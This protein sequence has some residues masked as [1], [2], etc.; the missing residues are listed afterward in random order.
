MCV[1]PASHHIVTLTE[2]R[3]IDIRR[4]RAVIL[5]EDI[6]MNKISCRILS[7]SR[8]DNAS[9][10][11]SLYKHEFVYAATT[12]SRTISLLEPIVSSTGYNGKIGMV[13]DTPMFK[14]CAVSFGVIVREAETLVKRTKDVI[15]VWMYAETR[16]YALQTSRQGLLHY[17]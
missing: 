8:V 5:T 1:F 7:A 15:N 9:S 16:V 13:H 14:L 6:M 3:R 2:K 4:D 10:K 17:I 12:P 11:N